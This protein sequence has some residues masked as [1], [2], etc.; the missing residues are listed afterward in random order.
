MLA[1]APLSNLVA[2]Q[3]ERGYRATRWTTDQGLPQN[4]ISYLRQTRDGYVW[5]GTW[6][7]LARFDGL[8]YTVFDKFNTSALVDDAITDLA[9]D[10]EGT[11]WIGT[12]NGLVGYRS[13]GFFRLTARDGLP[14]PRVDR[15][16]ADERGPLWV[17]SGDLITCL[18]GGHF[19]P[20]STLPPCLDYPTRW[21]YATGRGELH[22]LGYRSWFTVSAAGSE[23]R[24]HSHPELPDAPWY[25]TLP[26][27]GANSFWIGTEAGL[28]LWRG[29]EWIQS[30][31]A[32]LRRASINGL[33][34]DRAGNVWLSLASGGLLRWNESAGSLTD[35][36]V[37]SGSAPVTC[38]MEDQE[39]NLWLGTE[40]G[41]VH[42]QKRQVQAISRSQGLPDDHAWSVC[43]A[44]DGSIWTGTRCGLARLQ[45]DQVTAIAGT[46]GFPEIS[47]WPSARGGVWVA[48]SNRGVYLVGAAQEEQI[49]VRLDANL[50]ALYED[51]AHRLWIGTGKGIEVHA[52]DH[53]INYY[54]NWSGCAAHDVRCI[55]EDHESTFWLG[56]QGQGLT[57]LREG[58]F[59]VFTQREGLSS[60]RVW[61]LYEDAERT[62]WIGT[63]N[64]LM[65]LAHGRFFTFARAQGLRENAVNCVLEDDFGWLW[66]SGL[67][68][69]YRIQ[70]QQLDAMAAGANVTLQVAAFGTA[71]GMESSETNGENQPSGWKAKDGRVWF[72]TVLGLVVIDPKQIG[73]NEMPPPVVIEDVFANRRSILAPQ[74][75]PNSAGPD[76]AR[77]M[78]ASRSEME[79]RLPA[80]SARVL[81]FRYAANHFASPDKVRFRF[82]LEGHDRDWQQ[83]D[84]NR[85]V[86][87][88]TDL[89][90]RHY[91][92]VVKA[93]NNHGVWNEKGDAIAFAIAPFFYQ[94]IPFY[95]LTALA[96]GS[97]A[98]WLHLS[99]VKGINRLR[100]LE[101]QHSLDLERARIARDLHDDLGSRFTE[102]A[103]LREMTN[104]TL[105]QG[106]GAA[107]LLEKMR[108][109]TNA[110][111]QSL[112]E[113]VWAVNPKQDSVSGLASYLREFAVGFLGPAGIQCRLD[114]P[115]PMP[116]RTLRAEVRH[117]LFLV[118]KE[119]LQ[120]VVKHA[121]ALEVCLH[122]NVNENELVLR[123]KDDGCGLP[124]VRHAGRI[125]NGLANMR[126]RVEQIGGDFV[127]ASGNGGGTEIRV[128][129]PL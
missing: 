85:R 11:L 45:D 119:A 72:P 19:A 59:Q 68:G 121:K 40:Q 106:P 24:A 77:P 88:Y 25:A 110:A 100:R 96:L 47:V 105:D 112:D 14:Q 128:R 94:T 102:I 1:V 98:V 49:P 62:L 4:R 46:P 80:G 90:P 99:R 82:K 63:E 103:V 74:S 81:E 52:P 67:R 3:R 29:N 54:T 61:C 95:L 116:D 69:I 2:A 75:T 124:P 51:R 118:V 32:E 87:F 15:L 20:T 73:Q 117:Q 107:S 16:C 70:R 21:L 41:L 129:L 101:Q 42:L 92:F 126:H 36:T 114:F 13:H 39:G 57:R 89:P 31:P 58:Q 26:G 123:V 5:V 10:Q 76:L 33:V 79:H 12:P 34:R 66:L 97:A 125:G 65:R 53:S 60:D 83:D 64:G 55:L 48:R 56:T 18:S 38:L 127:L 22:V 104:R 71:D 113:I 7:G 17:Q 28:F 111:F 9:E 78:P 93:A 108:R 120:N 35:V 109:A 44:H 122:L 23:V 27:S 86:A 30:N 8:H 91:R 43:Q 84:R 37:E 6:F 50:H 115:S